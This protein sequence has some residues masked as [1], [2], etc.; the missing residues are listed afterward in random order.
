M[1]HFL[2]YLLDL[3]LNRTTQIDMWVGKIVS[4][5]QK[6]ILKVVRF[7]GIF[8]S[9]I[10]AQDSK[11]VTS[12]TGFE[13]IPFEARQ[14]SI[15]TDSVA[16]FLY[17]S[18]INFDLRRNDQI[19]QHRTNR[20]IGANFGSI[21]EI[22]MDEIKKLLIIIH[23]IPY[24]HCMSFCFCCGSCIPTFHRRSQ[25]DQ[26]LA[27]LTDREVQSSPQRELR[28]RRGSFSATETSRVPRSLRYLTMPFA[29]RVD[30]LL[31]IGKRCASRNQIR[32]VSRLSA[33]L[34]EQN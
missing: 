4:K 6:F 21:R 20:G 8:P 14:H 5:R 22:R 24:M 17:L 29:D 15:W 31:T 11:W 1:F 9:T 30:S 18:T 32:L 16:L 12:R 10:L 25:P 7:A 27:Q 23:Q 2:A 13:P 34:H 3:I 28:S 33:V 19:D 26:Y